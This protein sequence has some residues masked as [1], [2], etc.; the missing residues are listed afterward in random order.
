MVESDA[1]LFIQ[2]VNRSLDEEEKFHFLR[3]EFL[4]RLNL[5]HLQV[6]LARFKSQVQKQG[7]CTEI[8]FDALQHLLRNYGK[9]SLPFQT[10][11]SKLPKKKDREL[12]CPFISPVRMV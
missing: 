6:K 10:P 2:Y 5:V 9:P 3:F 11:N 12:E 8:E 4:Q 7:Q 1:K